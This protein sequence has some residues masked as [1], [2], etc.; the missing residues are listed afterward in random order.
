MKSAFSFSHAGLALL[1][2]AALFLA[3]CAEPEVILPGARED[4]RPET[5]QEA[6]ATAGNVSRAIALP[7]QTSNAEW[8]QAFGTPTYRVANPALRSQPQRVWSTGIGSGDSRRQRITAD[9]VVAGGLIYTLDSGARVSGVTTSGALAWST[10]L[11]PSTDKEGQATGG[12]MAY[13]DG[14]LYVSSGFGRLTALDAR[15]G[16]VRWQQRLDATGSGVPTIY[17][18]LIYL[19]A[20]DDTGWAVNTKDGRIAWQIEATPSVANVLGA[21]APALTSQYAIFA[22]GSGDIVTAFRRGG[23]RRWA[24]SVAGQRTGW[25]GSR[26]GDVTGS[27]V[28]V[29]GRVYAGNHSGRIAAFEIETGERLWTARE[30]AL[31]PVW[32]AGDSIFAVTDR[33]QLARFDANSGEIVW[34]VDLP[35]FLRDK[36]RKRAAVYANYGPILAGGRI[37]VASSDGLLRFF[38]PE[39]GALTGTAEVPGGATTAPVVAGN[40]LYVVGT[41]GDLHAFR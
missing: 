3:A 16:A 18:G 11:V 38:S 10:E 1:G 5:D 33:N 8:A 2:S 39:S 28:I 34:A 14:V 23:L 26:I 12:G 15:T 20:G 41:K 31:G 7:A 17:E 21:P 13:S 30:G 29:G 37:V 32:P 24:G 19:V 40:T 27:P 9:P 22:F 4:I 36:P 35:G 6:A 25:A